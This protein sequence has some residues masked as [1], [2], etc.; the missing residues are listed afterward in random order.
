M[1]SVK[2]PR[3]PMLSHNKHIYVVLPFFYGY[4]LSSLRNDLNCAVQVW[5]PGSN[6]SVSVA[7]GLGGVHAINV[8]KRS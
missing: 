6:A 8:L 1:S 7:W 2:S 3:R 5:A 4:D